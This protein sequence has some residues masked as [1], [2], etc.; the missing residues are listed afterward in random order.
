MDEAYQEELYPIR[1]ASPAAVLEELLAANNFR[2][3]DLAPLRGAESDMSEAL[4]RKRER[5]SKRFGVSPAVF[6][7]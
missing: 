6:F 7:G 5:L 1:G 3:K 4:E 2:Q